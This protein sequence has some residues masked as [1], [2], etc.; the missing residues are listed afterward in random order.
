MQ[1][2]WRKEESKIYVRDFV[3]WLVIVFFSVFISEFFVLERDTTAVDRLFTYLLIFIPFGTLNLILHY[4]YRNRR[5]RQTGNLR[6]SLR[7]RL[8]LAFML[9][10]IIP[11]IPIFIISSNAVGDLIERYMKVD[12]TGALKSAERVILYYEKNEMRKFLDSIRKEFPDSFTK[13]S[14]DGA[15][16]LIKKSRGLSLITDYSAV[17]SENRIV[18]ESLPIFASRGLPVF[19]FDV[20]GIA[21]AIQYLPEG[22]FLL[23]GFPLS[24]NS[25]FLISGRKLHPGFEKDYKHFVRV[26][27]EVGRETDWKSGIPATFRLA[28]ALIYIFMIAAA[29]IVSILIARQISFPIVSLAAATRDVTDGKIETKLDIKAKGEIG[30]LIESFNQMTEELINLRKM[31][32]HGQRVAAWQEV[33]KRLAHEIKNPLTP[34]QLSADRMLRRLDYPEKGDLDKIVRTGASTIVEQVKILKSMVEEFAT[35]ARMPEAMRRKQQINPIVVEAVNLFR[36]LDDMTIEKRLNT[37]LP[38]VSIDKNI[39]MGMINNLIK[40]AI[41]AIRSEGNSG[42]EKR[43]RIT[44]SLHRERGRDFVVLVVEDTGPGIDESLR[45]RIFEPYFTTK[46]EHGGGLGLALVERAVMEHGARIYVGRSSLGG[47]EFRIV[48]RTIE[49]SFDEEDLRS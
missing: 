34:I 28:I 22:D 21:Y 19:Q 45:E 11:S 35:F 36:G 29:L 2:N 42:K 7:Y 17:F 48:F 41:E 25:G 32:L 9:V 12:F 15:V 23:I 30:V 3:F 8:S 27:E 24:G 37:D 5:I 31:Q 49:E 6:S 20:D 16:D 4:F 46:G 33:A 39:I 1:R 18:F 10:S 40:N 13:F 14:S 43:V 47:A 38:D 44:T 26:M